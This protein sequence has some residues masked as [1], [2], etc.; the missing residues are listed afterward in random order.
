[1][2]YE[3]CNPTFYVEKFR[4]FYDPEYDRI[5]DESVPK[6]QYE[7]FKSQSW[8]HKT[9]AQFLADNFTDKGFDIILVIDG[10]EEYICNFTEI[11]KC[12][13][14]SAFYLF[15]EKAGM[16]S[17]GRISIRNYDGDIVMEFTNQD[18]LVQA[19]WQTLT[20]VTIGDDECIDQN[21]F[22]FPTGTFREDIWRWFDKKHSKG[23]AWLMYEY[24]PE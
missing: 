13:L 5:V 21:W 17:W 6:R 3:E 10:S 15:E 24:E 14:Y 2:F 11:E 20:D 18:D 4:R 9:Y 16:L 19:V 23:V 12:I 22:I 1:M 8:F 7:W